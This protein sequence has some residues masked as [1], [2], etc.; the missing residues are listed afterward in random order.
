MVEKRIFNYFLINLFGKGLNIATG[1]IITPIL[2]I[3]FDKEVFGQIA[4]VLTIISLYNI[5]DFGFSKSLTKFI[6]INSNNID[7]YKLISNIYS[8]SI[9]LQSCI[10]FLSIS[11]FLFF[12]KISGIS[13]SFDI[14]DNTSIIQNL[15]IICLFC[16]YSVNGLG[17]AIFEGNNNFGEINII[18]SL[19]SILTF[20]SPLIIKY[21][22]DDYEFILVTL[23]GSKAIESFFINILAQQ[24][25]KISFLFKPNFK[26][27]KIIFNEG[28]YIMGTNI[29]AI[30]NEYPEKLIIVYYLGPGAYSAYFV[31]VELINRSLVLMSAIITSIFP[32]ESKN[33]ALNKSN[34][35]I[36]NIYIYTTLF[37]CA[38]FT[39]IFYEF[40]EILSIIIKDSI[41]KEIS[42]YAK[43]LFF[44]LIPYSISYIVI[45]KLIAAG[46]SKI[47]LNYS[48]IKTPIYICFVCILF[49][50]YGIYGLTFAWAI[51]KFLECLIFLNIVKKF[52][53]NT[54]I[55]K[56]KTFA[57]T[58]VTFLIIFFISFQILNLLIENIYLRLFFEISFIVLIL[59]YIKNKSN[60]NQIKFT[61]LFK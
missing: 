55:L 9:Y 56:V 35:Y 18:R 60:N 27:V 12:L 40:E 59:I 23:V 57:K 1:I 21:L 51:T 34:K 3:V 11:A 38:L 43:I 13:N 16:I 46:K 5:F 44:G 6:A 31:A 52:N 25:N 7:K 2:L 30:L 61:G 17:R 8:S 19:F 42:S 22:F 49:I 33:I 54:G 15:L 26:S 41:Y 58:I 48:C 53:L 28:I 37:Y 47:V 50:N 24:K 39:I 10:A 14:Y 45:N 36:E 32:S 4:I 20:S 29:I